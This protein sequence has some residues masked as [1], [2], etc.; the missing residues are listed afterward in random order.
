MS[1]KKATIAG[2]P[3]NSRG[4]TL[5]EIL[6]AVAV[7]GLV[8]AAAIKTSGNAINNVLYLRQQT[9]AHWIAMNKAA[10][11]E[12]AGQWPATGTQTGIE[13]FADDQWPWS[14]TGHDTPDTDMRRF[15]IAIRAN[16]EEGEPVSTLTVFL[17]RK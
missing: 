14:I 3:R 16:S 15:E 10:E 5:L 2:S 12:L 1:G 11:L 7:L 4:F 6:V 17:G 13:T 8:A 9:V